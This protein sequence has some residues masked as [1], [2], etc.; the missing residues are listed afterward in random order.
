M[1][2]YT[3]RPELLPSIALLANSV[4]LTVISASKV[5]FYLIFHWGLIHQSDSAWWV[6]M[7]KS[8]TLKKNRKNMVCIHTCIY[9]YIHTHV[10]VKWL[11]ISPGSERKCFVILR[12]IVTKLK[13]NKANW[14]TQHKNYKIILVWNSCPVS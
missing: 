13:K 6:L 14:K 3:K 11:Q 2:K 5:F 4:Q 7:S 8:F 1:P 9:L 10:S 12:Y